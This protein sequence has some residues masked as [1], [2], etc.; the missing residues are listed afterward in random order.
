[1]SN[2]VPRAGRYRPDIDGLRAIAILAVLA[3]HAFPAVAPG[4]FVGV[5]VF[6]VISGYLITGLLL[7]DLA[8]GR[9]SLLDF[10][11]RRIRRIFP[12]L[13]VVLLACLGYGWFALRSEVYALLGRQV[14]WGAGFA[15]NLLQWSEAGYFN[16]AGA[17]K[18]LLHLWSLGIEEQFYL[19]WPLLLWLAWRVRG[20]ARIL[21]ALVLCASLAYALHLTR[22]AP[23]AAFFSPFSRVWELATGAMLAIAMRQRDASDGMPM[24]FATPASIAGLA[25]VVASI[26]LL[27]P[28]HPYPGWRALLPVSGSALLIAAGPGALANRL[29]LS[30]RTMIGIGLVSYPLYLWHWPLLV[31]QNFDNDGE[32]AQSQRLAALALAF[33][34]AFL[35]Y[36]FIETPLRFGPRARRN[37]WLLAIAM[38]A[39]GLAGAAIARRDGLPSRFRGVE[40]AYGAYR[41]DYRADAR[42]PDCWVSR[43]S[44]PDAYA[45]SCVDPADGR[46][47]LLLWGDS[48][49]GRLYPGLRQELGARYRIAQFTRSGCAPNFWSFHPRQA[50]AACTS[51][52]ILVMRRVQALRPEVVVVF[53]RWSGWS[54]KAIDR[55]LP[56]TVRALREN[57]AQRVI[58][59]GP[60]PEWDWPLPDILFGYAREHGRLAPAR[61]DRHL[62]ANRRGIDADMR[63]ALAKQGDAAYVSALDAFCDERGCLT[64]VGDD[65]AALTSWDY[66][67]LTTPA[68]RYLS[69]AIAA[70]A[71]EP[72]AGGPVPATPRAAPATMR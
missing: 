62:L 38:L 44:P 53:A 8:A 36:R 51:A 2:A 24:P 6:F 34:L 41:Y 72:D 23:V 56:R 20:G 19:A 39:T 15:S 11:R 12:A 67:H 5:D 4:G 10:Y 50:V 43:D 48:H 14:A 13:V 30:R 47:L 16:P 49:A 68:A 32:V 69:T 21:V 9:F 54:G 33:V 57:G 3:F 7:A 1:M 28:R 55:I 61:M 25:L 64:R 31:F 65:P 29:L 27:D 63:S 60:A 58:V 46:P 66:G 42:I 26:A 52:N 35:T 37:A 17:R 70:V 59:V 18:P 22:S 45:A 40:A 71:E